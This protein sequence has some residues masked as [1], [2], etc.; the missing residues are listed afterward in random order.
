MKGITYCGE[1][2]DYDHKKHRCKRGAN[3]ES[4]PQDKFYDGCTVG[5]R[6]EDEWIRKF[7]M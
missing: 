1:C 7:S 3:R 4:N 6:C 2:A 5:W